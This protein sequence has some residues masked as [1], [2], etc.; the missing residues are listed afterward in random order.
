LLADINNIY[1]MKAQLCCHS[2]HNASISSDTYI[3]SNLNISCNNSNY[4]QEQGLAQ[5]SL[6]PRGEWLVYVGACASQ[7]LPTTLSEVV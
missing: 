6:S 4:A 3:S 2:T 1:E 7:K 5:A